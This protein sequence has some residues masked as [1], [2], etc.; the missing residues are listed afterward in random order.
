MLKVF[1]NRQLKVS[2]YKMLM[3]M[4]VKVI[5]IYKSELILIFFVSSH[6]ITFHVLIV[7]YFLRKVR[8]YNMD[9]RIETS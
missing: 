7:F 5:V 1:G 3:I 2:T 6:I 8:I 4:F 9:Q